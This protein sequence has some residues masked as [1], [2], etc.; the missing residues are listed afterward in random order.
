MHL[1]RLCR[2]PFTKEPLSG[3]GGLF[4]SGRWHTAPR[5]VVYASQSLALA[6]L[7]VLVHL[8][9]DLV[10]ADLM[11]LEID[12]P[13]DVEVAEIRPAEL[14]R[15]WR[16]YPASRSL[17]KIGNLWLDRREAALLCVPSAIIPSE[18]NFLINPLHEA[19]Q[20]IRVVNKHPFGM[21]SRL[22]SMA[23]RRS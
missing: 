3:K 16:R 13:S 1:W 5:L 19:A 2:R 21:D 15:S 12:V 11:A 20:Q 4:S 17:Q 6:T 8:D 23:A 14:P 10:P 18:F 22:I 7:E 9:N